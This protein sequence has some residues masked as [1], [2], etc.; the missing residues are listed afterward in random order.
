MNFEFA[1]VLRIFVLRFSSFSAAVEKGQVLFHHVAFYSSKRQR[2]L[3]CTNGPRLFIP[4]V[5]DHVS[6]CLYFVVRAFPDLPSGG[7]WLIVRNNAKLHPIIYWN[8]I[9]YLSMPISYRSLRFALLLYRER[10][11]LIRNAG[12]IVTTRVPFG[13]RNIYTVSGPSIPG[14]L[15]TLS[16]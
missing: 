14:L 9:I 3:S 1:L 12:I 10:A 15:W 2:V 4:K 8:P 6:A 11:D 7:W 16:I 5:T 13:Q